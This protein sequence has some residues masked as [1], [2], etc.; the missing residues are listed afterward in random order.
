MRT[1][2]KILHLKLYFFF[3]K[4]GLI[5]QKQKRKKTLYNNSIIL[6]H[7]SIS[8]ISFIFNKLFTFTLSPFFILKKRNLLIII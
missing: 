5:V 2:Q 3:N 4:N 8:L 6:K 1:S 7:H